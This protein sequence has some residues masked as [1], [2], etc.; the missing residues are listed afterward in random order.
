MNVGDKLDMLAEKDSSH[1]YMIGMPR[2]G[3]YST[4]DAETCP[5]FPSIVSAAS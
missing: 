4:T 2:T 3:R 1:R 5:I